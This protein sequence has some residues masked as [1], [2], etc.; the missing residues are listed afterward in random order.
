M[1][2]Q[3]RSSSKNS[4]KSEKPMDIL[5]QKIQD[6]KGEIYGIQSQRKDS[7]NPLEIKICDIKNTRLQ[8]M[9]KQLHKVEQKV[10]GNE[11][12][13]LI[14]DHKTPS[15]RQKYIYPQIDNLHLWGN[16]LS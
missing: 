14:Q 1:P 3:T 6:L 7:M 2:I 11:N 12:Q 15:P 10:I 8:E 13:N 9:L 4:D 16:L 5:A